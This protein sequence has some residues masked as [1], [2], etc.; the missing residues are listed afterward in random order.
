MS[1][2][3]GIPL[4]Q[5]LATK[6][7]QATQ[8]ASLRFI[9]VSIQDESLVHDLS[10][11]ASASF[12][13]DFAKLNDVLDDNTPAYVLGKQDDGQ[14]I[15]IFYVP[16]SARVRDKMLYASTRASLLKSLGSTTF[17]DSV[18]ATSK[19]DL[20]PEAYA[21]HQRHLAAPKPLS[22][23]EQELADL[24]AAE[25]ATASYDGSRSRTSHVGSAVGLA[26]SVDAKDAVTDLGKGTDSS[27]VVLQIDTQTETLM[28][29]S[30]SDIAIDSLGSSIPVSEPSFTLLAWPHSHASTKRREIVFIYSCPSNSP[31]K[32]RMVYSSAS[33][34]TYMAA[35]T[36]L[37]NAG[38]SITFASR[39]VE[40]SDPIEL[41]KAYLMTALGYDST[42]S[43]RNDTQKQEEKKPFAK[44]R[45]PARR[46]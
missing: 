12:D 1:A 31:I 23:R 6:F 5:D 43:E 4:T 29:Q 16:D 18:F 40:T 37:Q 32:H 28:L 20:T 2:T 13:Q 14:W 33:L 34:S 19:A 36:L 26:W 3:S 44:P 38:P 15:A 8:D 24:R 10:V 27:I 42:T 45:G 21:S 9:K 7:A 46:Q 30:K 25:S 35:Q 22:T 17:I 39:K 41:D 11:P